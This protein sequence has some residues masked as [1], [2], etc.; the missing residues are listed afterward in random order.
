MNIASVL[1]LLL[2]KCYVIQKVA[3]LFTNRVAPKT[4]TFCFVRLNFIKYWL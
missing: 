1:Q 2:N 3:V 4:C